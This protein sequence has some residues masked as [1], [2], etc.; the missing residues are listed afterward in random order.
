MVGK[1]KR[2]LPMI[3]EADLVLTF[4]EAVRTFQSLAPK[5]MRTLEVL[6]ATGPQTMYALA[7]RLKRNYSNVHTDIKVLSG[8]GL[9]EKNAEGQ[10]MVPWDSVEIRFPIGVERKGKTR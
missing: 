10:V 2:R 8:F 6:R 1:S 9:V 3:A 4:R 5:R 7:K